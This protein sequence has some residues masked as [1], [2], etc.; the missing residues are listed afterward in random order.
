MKEINGIRVLETKDI[1]RLCPS[2]YATQPIHEVSEKYTFLSTHEIAKQLWAAGWMPTYAREQRSVNK[3]N[4]GFT[5]HIIRFANT[6]FRV[7]GERIEIVGVNSHNLSASFSLMAGVY[8]LVCSNGMIAQ[9]GDL[10][11]FKIK[12][13][14]DIG[15]QVHTAVKG[16]S[17]TASMIAGSIED[18]KTIDLT[19]DE[20]GVFASAAHNYIYGDDHAPIKP[21]ALL[22]TRRAVDRGSDLWSTFNRVQENVMKGGLRGVARTGRKT[23]TRNIKDIGKDVKLNKALWALTEKMADLKKAA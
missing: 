10:G 1:E 18:F 16:I 8:R 11:S 14:G 21:K 20:Q 3:T 23:R 9:T 6:A 13:I 4:V 17:D 5:R 12:H 19:P 15:E 7:N 22:T 2:F